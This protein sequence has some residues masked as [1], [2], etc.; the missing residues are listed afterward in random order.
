M[1]AVRCNDSPQAV[2]SP[3]ATINQ[4]HQ[5]AHWPLTKMCLLPS[6]PS[7]IYAL[8]QQTPDKII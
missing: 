8:H 6:V 3:P 2:G 7:S 5:A 4:Y 1:N